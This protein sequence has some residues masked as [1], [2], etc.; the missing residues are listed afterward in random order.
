[1]SEKQHI[2]TIRDVIK[3]SLLTIAILAASGGAVLSVITFYLALSSPDMTV[4]IA[5]NNHGEAY[6]ETLITMPLILL[7]AIAISGYAILRM[8]KEINL[9]VDD[10]EL[11]KIKEHHVRVDGYPRFVEDDKDKKYM[12]VINV[13]PHWRRK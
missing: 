3:Q 2:R 7:S 11:E 4:I 10:R 9:W 5:I 8:N 6:F 12:R 13:K 1:M